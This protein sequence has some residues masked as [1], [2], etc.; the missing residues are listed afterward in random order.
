MSGLRIEDLSLS[1]DGV[2]VLDR[3]SLAVKPG[4]FVSILGPSGCG[5]STLFR[6][7]IG[8]IAP[9]RGRIEYPDT[10]A[11]AFAFMP[12]R[13][14]LLPWRRVI[15]N[16]TLGL[17]IEGLPRREARARATP[18]MAEFGLA[19]FERHL[20]AQLSGGM[21]QRAALLRTV[22]QGRSVQLLDEPF[23]ALDALTRTR[24]QGW[25]EQR[26]QAAGWTTLLVTHDVRE[27]VALSDRIYVLSP[28][29][30]RVIAEFAVT[31]PRPRLGRPLPATARAI[32]QQILDTIF[33]ASGD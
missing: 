2:P 19:G 6:L 29:P 20:P 12:Q 30:A 17:E 23:G 22:I 1:L 10:E 33:T 15:D 16:V 28:R 13:D 31:A 11:G 7:L 8:E 5:K 27:A 25:F 3:L 32:E 24:I 18:M 9:D 26:W 4:E 14:A 21:R